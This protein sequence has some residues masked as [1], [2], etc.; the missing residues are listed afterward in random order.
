MSVIFS[1]ATKLILK[2]HS[3]FY[4]P[5]MNKLLK[6]GIKNTVSFKL[7][8]HKMKHLGIIPTKYVSDP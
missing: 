6:L 7:A 2:R 8:S 3:L 1:Q 4:I 5:A